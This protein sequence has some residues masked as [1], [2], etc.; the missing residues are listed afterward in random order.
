MIDRIDRD[1]FILDRHRNVVTRLLS[2]NFPR[3]TPRVIVTCITKE[4]DLNRGSPLTAWLTALADRSP[5]AAAR[6]PL[7]SP[8]EPLTAV[9]LPTRS[10]LRVRPK[11]ISLASPPRNR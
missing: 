11:P 4:S 5:L 1:R 9:V 3:L 10:K 8:E 6:S 7:G 2:V